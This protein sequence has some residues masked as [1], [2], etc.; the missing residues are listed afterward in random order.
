MNETGLAKTER[1]HVDRPQ[2]QNLALHII[3]YSFN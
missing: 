3:T 1:G 2:S